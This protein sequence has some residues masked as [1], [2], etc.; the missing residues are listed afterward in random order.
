MIVFL[1][2]VATVVAVVTC[3]AMRIA[4]PDARVP[5]V[6]VYTAAALLAIV[7]ISIATRLTQ[8]L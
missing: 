7:C 6:A 5:K 4:R 1:T 3:D 2:G 8:L